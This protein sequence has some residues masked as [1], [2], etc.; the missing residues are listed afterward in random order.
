MD[1]PMP[2]TPPSAKPA[3]TPV[4]LSVFLCISLAGVGLLFYQNYELRKQNDVLL[5]ALSRKEQNVVAD[6]ST[7]PIANW[8]TYTME[9]YG[10]SMNYPPSLVL[11]EISSDIFLH[12]AAF[13]GPEKT[14]V[15]GIIV[16][17][18]NLTNLEDEIRY[19]TW[20]IVGHIAD[21]LDS[22][23]PISV[24][25]LSGKRLNYTSGQKQFSTVILPY[26]KFVYVIQAENNLL[27][28]VLSTFTFTPTVITYTC[29]ETEY[30]DCMPSVGGGAKPQCEKDFLSWAQENCSGFKG[31]AY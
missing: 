24:S 8:K 28:Q 23:L 16:E 7:D 10:Y 21:K 5:A 1:Q 12:Q 15:S 20:R 11:H 31:A 27:D 30:V 26:Q 3:V 4:I 14:Y 25:G 29:P 22:E 19:R 9:K 17:V 2:L 13:E 6:D 18:R